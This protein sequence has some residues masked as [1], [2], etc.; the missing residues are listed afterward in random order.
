MPDFADGGIPLSVHFLQRGC[1]GLKTLVKK[2]WG[3]NC[4]EIACA[5]F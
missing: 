2:Q 1:F 5:S 4:Y 3:Q